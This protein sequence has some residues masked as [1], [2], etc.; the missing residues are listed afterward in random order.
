MKNSFS[1]LALI[2]VLTI[3][4]FTFS[5]CSSDDDVSVPKTETVELYGTTIPYAPLEE[6]SLPEWLIQLKSDKKMMGLHSI[7]V[8]TLN[9]EV[10]Y[11]LDVW[12]DSYVGGRL[13]DKD[14]NFISFTLDDFISKVRN[15]R[16]VYINKS[17]ICQ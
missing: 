9:D 13:Y 8:G 5:A 10:V 12:T 15:F 7:C 6:Q 4:C 14:G 17:Y 16:C 11:H 3:S 2:I 1:Y